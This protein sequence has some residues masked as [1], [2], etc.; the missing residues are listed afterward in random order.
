MNKKILSLILTALI[1]AVTMGGCGNTTGGD[2]ETDPKVD[3]TTAEAVDRTKIG[4]ALWSSTDVLGSRCKEVICDAA[5]ALGAEVEFSDHGYDSESMAASVDELIADGCDGIVICNS[6][7]EQ[8][9][10]AIDSCDSAGVYLAQCFRTINRVSSAKVFKKAE[11]SP[12]YV[13]CVHENEIEAGRNTAQMVLNLRDKRIGV[14]GW[15]PDDEAWLLRQEGY[16]IAVD[17][18]NMINSDNK[19]TLLDPVYAGLSFEGGA[20]A[21]TEL[22]K[23]KPRI[24]AII[25][26]GGGGEPLAGVLSAVSASGRAT[27]IHVVA[28]DFVDDLGARIKSGLMVG[29]SGGNF[30]D[31][32]LAFMMVYNA[33]NGAD[34]YTDLSG[35][36]NEI[37]F[38]Y[39]YAISPQDYKDFE[40]KFIDTAPYT[41]EGFVELSKLTVDELQKEASSF[42]K[43]W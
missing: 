32:L 26:A 27:K 17:G 42:K 12:Y 19:V 3:D 14:I 2:L 29:A 36:Y 30:C 18:A 11:D 37:V 13:G 35:T 16:R 28:T 40:K 6:T 41:K 15:V 38:P 4:V 24:D 5:E 33:V 31:P 43:K 1:L 25:V 34:T 23:T 22:L 8:M 21:A 9:D 20:E 10:K 7:D 39:L